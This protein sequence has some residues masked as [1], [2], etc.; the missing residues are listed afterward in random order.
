VGKKGKAV[1]H[2]RARKGKLL[3]LNIPSSIWKELNAL[4]Y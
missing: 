2:T 3:V 4:S 1:I